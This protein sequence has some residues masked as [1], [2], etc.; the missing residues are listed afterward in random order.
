MDGGLKRGATE[1]SGGTGHSPAA[2][3][4]RSFR[5]HLEVTIDSLESRIM[6]SLSRDFHELRET[7]STEISRLND[8]V[9]D[10]E[11]HIEER[12]NVI[13]GLSDELRRSRS[14][15]SALQTR[16][17]DAEMNSRLPCLILSGAAMASRHAPRLGPPVSAQTAPG[18]AGRSRP[19]GR[20]QGQAAAVTSQPAGVRSGAGSGE[21][22]PSAGGVRRGARGAGGGDWEEREDVDAL[23]VNTLNRSMPGLNMSVSDIDRAHRLPGPNNRVI[24]RF[25]RSGQCSVRD[26]V[27]SRRLELRGRELFV[28]ESL[29][30]LRSQIFRSLLAAKREK[31]LYTVYSRGGHVFYKEKQH[32]VGKRVDSLQCV[33]E[34]GFTV[35]E[36]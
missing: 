17:E 9:A 18:A 34:Q 23:V 8:R 24:V 19:A 36:R 28:N 33:R 32:G 5:E 1:P 16:V 20:G 3:S 10:L 26:Q 31:K 13:T 15:V 2:L 30:R 14:E 6:A 21:S 27:M 11:R 22:A 7:L 12:D 35:V 4:S 25:V 29:T